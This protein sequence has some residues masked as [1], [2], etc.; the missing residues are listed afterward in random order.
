MEAALYQWS[1]LQ[2]PMEAAPR[3]NGGGST[4]QRIVTL[5]RENS[6]LKYSAMPVP[7][8]LDTTGRLSSVPVRDV[9][10]RARIRILIFFSVAFQMTTKNKFCSPKFFANTESLR[11]N[12]TVARNP[13]FSSFFA[14]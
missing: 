12:K 6:K 8:P 10:I 3:T 7:V 2:V 1:W 13:G 14:R 4:Y 5:F 9:L 11:S